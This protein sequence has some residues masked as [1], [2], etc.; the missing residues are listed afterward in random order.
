[1]KGVP[2]D[3]DLA[4]AKQQL[5]SLNAFIATP[6]HTVY[7]DSLKDAIQIYTDHID[8]CIPRNEDD[9]IHVIECHAKRDQARVG[10]TLF[11]DS[12]DLLEAAITK[13]E[14]ENPVTQH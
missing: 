14:A 11:E 7:K 9:R 2:A 1:M 4:K 5:E 12:R 13:Y 3:F 10:L 6:A 8:T